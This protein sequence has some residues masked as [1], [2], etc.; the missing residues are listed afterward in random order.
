MQR[1]LIWLYSLSKKS[2]IRQVEICQSKNIFHEYTFSKCWNGKSI[3][4][5]SIYHNHVFIFF[6]TNHFNFSHKC[7]WAGVITITLVRFYIW[8]NGLRLIVLCTIIEIY[9]LYPVVF[10][11][12][13]LAPQYETQGDATDLYLM[14]YILPRKLNCWLD[15]ISWRIKH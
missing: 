15:Y 3:P 13:C 7:I 14:R 10:Q 9:C 11:K 8:P 5:L 4:E 1:I 2:R 6:L 12:V